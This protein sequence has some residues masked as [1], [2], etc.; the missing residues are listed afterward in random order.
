LNTP[1]KRRRKLIFLSGLLPT[2]LCFPSTNSGGLL[3]WHV[4]VDHCSIHD[5]QCKIHVFL[6]IVAKTFLS[7]IILVK[8]WN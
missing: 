3:G 7:F 1:L 4:F 5:S 2:F 6:K 8:L